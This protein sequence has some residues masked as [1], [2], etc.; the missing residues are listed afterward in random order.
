VYRDLSVV[1]SL[2]GLPQNNDAISVPLESPSE[3]WTARYVDGYRLSTSQLEN[4]RLHVQPNELE[5]NGESVTSLVRSSEGWIG[6]YECNLSVAKGTLDALHY[7]ADSVWGTTPALDC[8]VPATLSVVTDEEGLPQV[9][10]RFAEA[11]PQGATLDLRFEAPISTPSGAVS[12][13]RIQSILPIHGAHYLRVPTLVDA[14]P[15]AWALNGVQPAVLPA[16]FRTF[17]SQRIDVRTFAATGDDFQIQ[18]RPR[19]SSPKQPRVRLADTEISSDPLTG[20]VIRTVFV[21]EPQGLQDC[22]IRLPEMQRLVDVQISGRPALVRHIRDNDWNVVLG[23]TPLPRRLEVL[24][25]SV[26]KSADDHQTE[27][28][29]AI[30]LTGTSP[31]AIEISLWSVGFPTSSPK[32]LIGVAESTAGDLASLR[33]DRMLSIVESTTAMAIESPAPDGRHWYQEWAGAL[34][35][36]RDE[37]RNTLAQHGSQQGPSQIT[38]PDDE[39]IAASSRRLDAWIERCDEALPASEPFSSLVAPEAQETPGSLAAILPTQQRVYCITDGSLDR[40]IVE[41]PTTGSGS[42]QS[43]LIAI[44]FVVCLAVSASFAM[45]YPALG[46]L[47]HRWP[48]A[49]TFLFGIAYWA[50]LQPSWLGLLISGASVFFACCSGW[51]GRAIRTDAS[52]VLRTGRPR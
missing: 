47:L 8:S 11:L 17:P 14:Q 19:L 32:P 43:Q 25:R 33:F 12:M 9:V 45:R 13:P 34:G 39:Q 28:A 20:Q 42:W 7:R 21:I 2:S 41:Y 18:M 24:S 3:S 46:D 51:P 36:L 30:L 4:V 40:L 38:R 6:R 22:T 29:R 44:A 50:W 52:T 48:H 16:S 26:E 49:L 23:P 31:I 35:T 10:V 1:L 27:I 5:L 15:V 37:T